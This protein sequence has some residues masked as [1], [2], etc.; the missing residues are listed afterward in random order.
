MRAFL[1]LILTL[2]LLWFG[3]YLWF[4]NKLS[5]KEMNIAYQTDAIVVLTG[6]Q[7]RLSVAGILLEEKLAKKLYVSGVDSKVTREEL[8]QLLGT[9]PELSLCC[10]E[11]GQQEMPLRH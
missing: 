5:N 2:V 1:Y 8:I 9:S 4:I 10:V 3:G 6:G 11:S 7:N